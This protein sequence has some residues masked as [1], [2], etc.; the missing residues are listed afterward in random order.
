MHFPISA[1]AAA[2]RVSLPVSA[3]IASRLTRDLFAVL[4]LVAI[5]GCRG[6]QADPNATADLTKAVYAAPGGWSG[7]DGTKDHPFDLA[8][9]LSGKSPIRPGGTVWLR[10]G[11]FKGSFTSLL[12]GTAEAPITVRPVP[13]EHVAIDGAGVVGAVLTINGA[14]TVIRDFEIMDSD[15]QRTGADLNRAAGVDVHA[16]NSKVMNLVIHD[17]GSGIGMWSDAVNAEAYGNI[18]YYNG[19]VGTDRA[20]GHGIYTQNKTGIRRITDN[21]IFS[22][23]GIGLHAYGS[24]E[25]F[26]DD[27]QVEGNAVFNNGITGGD[28]N[29]LL[30]GHRIAN[31]PVLISNFTYDQPGAGN[32]IGYAAGC[33]DL[34]MKDNYFAALK[35]GYSIQLVNCTGDLQG[36]TLVGNTRGISGQTIVTH[37]ELAAKYP[38]NSFIDPPA[39][40]AKIFVRPNR[41]TPGRANIIVY[42]WGHTKDVRVDVSAAGIPVGGSYEI[43]DVRNLS[44]DPVA[45]GT[46]AG[47]PVKIPMQGLTAQPVVGWSQTPPHTAPEFG[48]FLLTSSTETPSAFGRMTAR[49][50]GMIGL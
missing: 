28:F 40:G 45:S 29:I 15:L 2:L 8:S 13:G 17:L 41:Y 39:T 14:W 50:R 35:G 5:A 37:P 3:R 48:A 21:V 24:E 49:L 47:S 7:G 10:A 34:R 33:T 11:T 4:L 42:N 19:W 9:A 30:G 31:R 25:A 22:Q 38:N 27:I 26:L 20:H 43:R 44:G 1:P 18:I 46:Y 23:F 12:T 6:Q 32:N 36:N 16:P